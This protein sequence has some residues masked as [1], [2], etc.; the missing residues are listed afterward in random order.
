MSLANAGCKS[1]HAIS[2][3]GRD[4]GLP[5]APALGYRRVKTPAALTLAVV[6]QLRVTA[7][8][9]EHKATLRLLGVLPLAGKVVPV[10]NQHG[11]HDVTQNSS[12]A[13]MGLRQL[14]ASLNRVRMFFRE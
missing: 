13:I 6:G 4:H 14:R 11:N 1:L 3:F 7:T 9:N 5:L 2:Q 10:T 12:F 8:T